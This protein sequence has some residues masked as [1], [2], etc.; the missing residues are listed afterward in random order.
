MASSNSS[1]AKRR[2]IVDYKN[3]T[4]EI[5]DLFTDRYPYGYDD[6]DVVRFKNAK[7][8]MVRAVPFET[9]DTKYLVK[10]SVQMDEH[11]ENFL[12]ED[13]DDPMP[14]DDIDEVAEEDLDD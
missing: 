11:I 2:V 10:V 5:L 9:P 13:N 7:G 12:D 14:G 4:S 1:D 3:V 6:S 8:E